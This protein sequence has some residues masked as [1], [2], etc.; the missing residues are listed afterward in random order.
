[1]VMHP[2]MQSGLN[3]DQEDAGQV[4]QDKFVYACQRLLGMD[5]AAAQVGQT[6]ATQIIVVEG[7]SRE[8]EDVATEAEAISTEVPWWQLMADI[9]VEAAL[10]YQHVQKVL[11]PLQEAAKELFQ[12]D[13]RQSMLIRQLQ[14][15]MHS[16]G[17]LNQT[18]LDAEAAQLVAVDSHNEPSE[19]GRVMGLWQ[20]L[21]D[22]AII[23]Q[24]QRSDQQL[25]YPDKEVESLAE[26][27]ARGISKARAYLPRSVRMG[28]DLVEALLLHL[29]H[30]IVELAAEYHRALKRTDAE[31][32][33]DAKVPLMCVM[34]QCR[35]LQ[36]RC[37]VAQERWVLQ[38]NCPNATIA[39]WHQQVG[40]WSDAVAAML[41][42]LDEAYPPEPDAWAPGLPGTTVQTGSLVEVYVAL[43]QA[44]E[45]ENECAL[46]ETWPRH[47]MIDE[48]RLKLRPWKLACQQVKQACVRAMR[49]MDKYVI[50]VSIIN[51]GIELR[52][53]AMNARVLLRGDIGADSFLIN[54]EECIQQTWRLIQTSNAEAQE[55]APADMAEFV[56]EPLL[57]LL[58]HIQRLGGLFLTKKSQTAKFNDKRM[59]VQWLCKEAASLLSLVRKRSVPS[60]RDIQSQQGW[61]QDEEEVWQVPGR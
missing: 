24:Q 15:L 57:A 26:M 18:K 60:W 32:G 11:Q 33:Y 43:Q 9:A 25:R 28:D 10:F 55:Q 3:S 53:A 16:R 35:S 40:S 54:V 7:C 48:V 52:A 56:W 22:G 21:Q 29:E 19:W 14:L 44:N 23:H 46:E 36:Q 51:T 42:P 58:P 34:E 37:T 47:M 39:S 6:V 27:A 30:A 4:L 20:A 59:E 50:P 8:F 45:A 13:R 1:M 49:S 17:K 31:D 2:T 41:R 38:R 61:F 5:R 12:G